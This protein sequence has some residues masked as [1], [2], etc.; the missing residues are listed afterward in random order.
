MKHSVECNFNSR[1]LREKKQAERLAMRKQYRGTMERIF[2]LERFVDLATLRARPSAEFLSFLQM[3]SAPEAILKEVRANM[4]AMATKTSSN[5]TPTGGYQQHRPPPLNLQAANA[6]DAVSVKIEPLSATEA[7][8]KEAAEE[9]SRP[10]SASASSSA[11]SQRQQLL[12]QRRRRQEEAERESRSKMI[13]Q[14]QQLMAAA[15]QAVQAAATEAGSITNRVGEWSQRPQGPAVAAAA[16]STAARQPEAWVLRRIGELAREGMWSPRRLPKVCEQPRPRTGHD[17][18]LAEMQWLSVDFS[19]ERAWKKAAARM[20]AHAAKE[21]VETWPERK[22]RA[23]ADRERKLKRIAAFQASE[24]EGFWSR[25]SGLA[26]ARARMENGEPAP[27][28]RRRRRRSQQRRRRSDSSPGSAVPSPSFVSVASPTTLVNGVMTD[29]GEEEVLLDDES[30][31]SEQERYERT[32]GAG[33]EAGGINE[34]DELAEDMGRPLSSLLSREYLE[35]RRDSG[36]LESPTEYDDEECDDSS[37]TLSS[38]SDSVD[39]VSSDVEVG[40]IDSLGASGLAELLCS[41]PTSVTAPRI[42]PPKEK[43]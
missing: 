23:R 7:A 39:D 34:L 19:Q 43:V 22:E 35:S 28:K 20:L 10:P 14:Q 15:V 31:I 32:R 24:V 12:N 5:K 25:M 29:G 41:L 8:R 21:F 18:L 2:S 36:V 9:D 16:A 40:E 13:F 11:S 26:D 1:R 6:A 30:T 42:P 17:G 3:S 4:E 27:K 33:P 38:L 37:S